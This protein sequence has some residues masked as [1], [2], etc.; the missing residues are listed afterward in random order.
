[1]KWLDKITDSKDLNL[2]KLQE[3]V[4]DKDACCAAVCEVAE[5]DMTQLKNNK[6]FAKTIFSSE[7]IVHNEF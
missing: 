2:S 6:N 5:Q 1:M 7:L 4:K 3:T